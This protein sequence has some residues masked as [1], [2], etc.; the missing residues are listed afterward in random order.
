MLEGMYVSMQAMDTNMEKRQSGGDNFYVTICSEDGKIEGQS[1]IV[2]RMNGTYDVF[3]SVPM[4]GAYLV[5]I[6]HMDLGDKPE[7][8]SIRGSPFK[9]NCQDPWTRQRV[10]GSTPNNRKGVQMT[11][12]QNDLLLFR[13][14]DSGVCVCNT[15]G[16]VGRLKMHTW[17]SYFQIPF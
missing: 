3:Y 8:L 1:C 13:A 6:K 5:H 7:K 4:P 9:V 14:S 10:M 16:Q 11:T 12:Y 15:D 17:Y 2:D